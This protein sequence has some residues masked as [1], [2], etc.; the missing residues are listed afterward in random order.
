MRLFCLGDVTIDSKISSLPIPGKITPGDEARI[1]FNCELPFG[2]TINPNSRTRGPRVL[3]DPFAARVF[4]KWAPGYAALATN[5][6]MDA[7][8]VGLSNTIA[9]LHRIGFDTIGA[10]ITE[11][12][13]EQPVF[14]E[15]PEGRLV[16]LN[17]VFPETH[18]DW[19]AVPGPNCWPGI[20]EST[21][22]IGDLKKEA[23]WVMVQVHWG[24]EL[25]PYPAPQERIIAQ[26]LVAS[27]ADILIGH[28]PHVVRGMEKINGTPVF[29]SLG[30]YYFP[31]IRDSQGNVIYRPAPRNKEALTIQVTFQRGQAPKCD[32]HSYW[33]DTSET[34][35]D[36]LNRAVRRLGKTST[37]LTEF[38]DTNY[39]QWYRKRRKLFDRLEY[40]MNFSLAQKGLGKILYSLLSFPTRI[41]KNG[42]RSSPEK[43]DG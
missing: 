19:K 6:I 2:E 39:M 25:F 23:D 32:I 11:E 38:K 9:S 40:R 26:E 29:Y 8:E 7:G 12:E 37:V 35:P 31:T 28:H 20:K 3:S 34:K 42:E 27:G 18:P 14:W 22:I 15:T 1:I 36:P 33:Q 5:H 13:I 24:D 21:K 30:N 41:I 17:W 43:H 16:I 4:E 10:G